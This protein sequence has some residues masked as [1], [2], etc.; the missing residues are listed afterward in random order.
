MRGF[1]VQGPSNPDR[2]LWQRP[3]EKDQIIVKTAINKLLA[4]KRFFIWYPGEQIQTRVWPPESATISWSLK[5][6]CL[7]KTSLK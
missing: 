6:I 7:M 3:C 5:P 4:S 2:S 1:V